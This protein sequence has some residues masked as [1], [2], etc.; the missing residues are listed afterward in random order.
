VERLHYAG[1]DTIGAW[2]DSDVVETRKTPYTA[3]IH[4][5]YASAAP[6]LP[7]PF[8]PM[9]RA[10]LREAIR[11]YPVAFGD[12]PWC[13][14]A[15][16]NNE[17]HWKNDAPLL[18][19]E[20]L[21]FT[22][23][24]T[25]AKAVF[26][27]WL[28]AKYSDVA[29]LNTAWQTDFSSWDDLLGR[30]EP[31]DLAKADKGDCSALATLFAEAYFR[32]VDEELTEVAPHI[33]YFGSRFNAASTEV[34]DAAAKYVDV[35]ST[36]F[37]GFVPDVGS[38][39][40]PGKPVLISEYHFANVGGSNLGSGLRSAQDSVQQARLVEHFIRDAVKHPSIVGAHWF[41]WRDQNVGGRYDGENY[42]VGYYDVVDLPK[43]DLIRASRNVSDTLYQDLNQ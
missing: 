36:N 6:K 15:F 26:R 19:K 43:E 30:V 16:V 21:D 20:V 8:D 3:I 18:V 17:L 22:E 23:K 34:I 5:S 10:E 28:K 12:D 29:A 9:T 24:P 1:I 13:I 32:M 14:G 35:I 25:A 11:E 40:R 2:S 42:D 41:Q 7:D 4:Y 27:D 39:A 31:K 37:Y 33:L 38:Y